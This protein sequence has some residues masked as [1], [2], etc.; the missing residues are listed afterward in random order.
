MF[1]VWTYVSLFGCIFL[2]TL[3]KAFG[4][5]F[6]WLSGFG[7]STIIL[8]TACPLFVY[9]FCFS[10]SLLNVSFYICYVR[11]FTSFIIIITISIFWS[12]TLYQTHPF[13]WYFTSAL[14]R[15]LL[16]AYPLFLVSVNLIWMTNPIDSYLILHSVTTSEL[17]S[18]RM[19]YK[20]NDN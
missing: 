10:G 13:H 20:L 17:Y 1:R 8:L 9:L 7:W 19:Y 15:S 4:N 2:S 11:T 12:F 16:V 14:P 18:R 6:Y 5:T 3:T